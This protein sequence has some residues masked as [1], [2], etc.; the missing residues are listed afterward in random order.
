MSNLEK[1]SERMRRQEARPIPL[2][3]IDVDHLIRRP[4]SARVSAI[5]ADIA[6]D[7]LKTPVE[8]TPKGDRWSLTKGWVRLEAH[9]RLGEEAIWAV[10]WRGSAAERAQRQ[11]DDNLLQEGCTAL[12]R[13]V[14]L[15]AGKAAYEAAEG[16]PVHGGAR[17][18]FQSLKSET[19]KPYWQ[20]AAERY[21]LSRPATFK[22][23]AVG[24]T[25]AP[26]AV[27]LLAE[28][29]FADNQSALEQISRFAPTQQAE[30][31]RLITGE[32]AKTLAAAIEAVVGAA[33]VT[34][35][36]KRYSAAFSNYA[37]MGARE[38]KSWM[39]QV[40]EDRLV[41]TGVSI[42]FDGDA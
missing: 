34:P 28:T 40:V 24:E 39:R 38:R 2:S 5:A 14:Y 3:Q 17:R 11:V 23:L 19:L 4:R 12:D 29:D 16:V 42:T 10:V 9:R 20:V 25:I 35:E 18:G 13:A 31:A 21:G 27:A 8:V 32:P 1:L 6:A 36:T 15:A 7:G 22:A 30:I 26:K 41:P 37:A 33:P